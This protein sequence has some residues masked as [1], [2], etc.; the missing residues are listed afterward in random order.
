MSGHRVLV[1][2]GAGYV[3]RFIVEGLL[4]AGYDV[5]VAGR[6]PPNLEQF[7][8]QVEFLPLAL[9][10]DEIHTATLEGFDALVH[11]AFYHM[12]GRYRGGEGDD[13]AAFRRLNL[14]GSVALFGAAKAAGVK[15]CVFLS[16]RAVYGGQPP[17]I[18]LTEET[19]C[20]P[21]TLYGEVKLTAEQSLADLATPDFVTASLRVTGVYG[22]ESHKWASLFDDFLAG[23]SV[24]PRVGTEVHGNDVVAAVRLMLERDPALVNG[25]SF[26]VSDILLDRRD[27][28]AL[29]DEIAGTYH[30]LPDTANAS[31][32]NAMSS[33]R[34]RAL[35]WQPGGWPLLEKTV[36]E[37]LA[38]R[39]G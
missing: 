21:D 20:H 15:C 12:P 39:A 30:A 6:S 35:G 3:G 28:L 2:G 7:A 34:L 24:E 36:S 22:G 11:A 10:P 18:E 9:E 19:P 8:K 38:E 27:L 4:Q 14:D 31:D 37:M 5:T 13:P 29:V 33:E 17:G 32:F 16:S 25:K 26:N 1:T 23:K